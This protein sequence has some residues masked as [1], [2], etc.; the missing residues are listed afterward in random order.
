MEIGTVSGFCYVTYRMFESG[1]ASYGRK[2]HLCFIVLGVK[3]SDC[4]FC[5]ICSLIINTSLCFLLVCSGI[6]LICFLK[7]P[8]L[9]LNSPCN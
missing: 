2:Q 9:G 4:E 1:L 6:S 8:E 5:M 3:I 7:L